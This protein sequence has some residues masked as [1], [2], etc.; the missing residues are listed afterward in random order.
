MQTR[1]DISIVIPVYNGAG[2]LHELFKRTS[3][4]LEALNLKY[5]ILF[6]D[7]GSEDLSWQIIL[8]LKKA[9]NDKIR[10]F[11]L[12]RNN[13]QQAATLCGLQQALGTWIVTL[14]DDLQT[15]PEEIPKLLEKSKDSM[16]DIVFGVYPSLKYNFIHNIGTRIFRYLLRKIA[17]DFPNGSSYRLIRSD[18]LKTYPWES[19]PWVNID[20]ML[21]WLTSNITTVTIRHDKKQNNHSRYSFFKLLNM[22]VTILIVNSVWP[23]RLMIWTGFFS[24]MISFG[25]GIFFLYKKLTI[26]A[27]VGFSALIV[28]ITFATGVILLC[29]GVLGEYIS[30]IYSMGMRHPAFIIKSVT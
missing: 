2:T 30:R 10:G 4:T 24:A 22:A 17:P 27:P 21:A 7:D 15:P 14:D 3:N 26:G 11:R 6:V 19:G 20:S 1:P 18:I 5:E 29:M 28:T 25:I 23:L 8:D 16:A 13:G 12:A 9:Y